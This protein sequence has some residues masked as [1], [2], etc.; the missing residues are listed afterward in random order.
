MCTVSKSD[1]LKVVY[2]ESK[3]LQFVWECDETF[4]GNNKL[5]VI[6]GNGDHLIVALSSNELHIV[7]GNGNELNIVHSFQLSEC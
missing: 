5:K 2:G 3:E 1:K 4:F 6:F 7:F